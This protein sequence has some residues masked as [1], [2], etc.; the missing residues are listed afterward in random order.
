MTGQGRPHRWSLDHNA[1]GC[2]A[3]ARGTFLD[4]YGPFARHDGTATVNS[5]ASWHARMPDVYG[6]AVRWVG[7]RRCNEGPDSGAAA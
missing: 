2:F 3:N 7:G 5:H 1:C 6:Y 4:A